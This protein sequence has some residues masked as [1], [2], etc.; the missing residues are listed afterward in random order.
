MVMNNELLFYVIVLKVNRR[1]EA[2]N[3][4]LIFRKDL[5]LNTDICQTNQLTL[6]ELAPF[7]SSVQF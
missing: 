5:T 6:L 4:F 7:E 3:S 2:N 1:F